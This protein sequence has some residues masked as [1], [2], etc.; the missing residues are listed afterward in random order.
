MWGSIKV[1]RRRWDRERG[2]SFRQPGANPPRSPFGP[3]RATVRTPVASAAV[4]TGV[5]SDPADR[6]CWIRTSGGN[7]SRRRGALGTDVPWSTARSDKLHRHHRHNDNSGGR[8]P[9]PGTRT[10]L[11][12][13]TDNPPAPSLGSSQ[14]RSESCAPRRSMNA[15]HCSN[16]PVRIRHGRHLDR[17]A[18]PSGELRPILRI[19]PDGRR[20]VIRIVHGRF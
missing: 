11:I 9:R 5:A 18:P 13:P 16:D 20:R 12:A 14:T 4:G 7:G 1:T 15:V 2:P 6:S 10:P 19:G 8:T 17:S 3:E